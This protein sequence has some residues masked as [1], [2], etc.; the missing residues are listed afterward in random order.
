MSKI[1]PKLNLNK[2]PQL[3]E[4]NSLIMAKN[5]RLLKDNTIGPDT[6]LEEIEVGAVIDHEE[7]ITVVDEEPSVVY[8]DQYSISI[9]K[10]EYYCRRKPDRDYL[11]T[12]G[13]YYYNYVFDPYN[14]TI[15]VQGTVYAIPNDFLIEGGSSFRIYPEE[16]VASSTYP[17]C[18]LLYLI[19]FRAYNGSTTFE[20]LINNEVA[21][22]YYAIGN[23][24]HVG[25]TVFVNNERYVVVQPW[26]ITKDS[27]PTYTG[28][29]SHTETINVYDP[30]RYI[31]Q[32]VGLNNKIYFFKEATE[33]QFTEAG[34]TYPTNENDKVRIFEYDEISK[35]FTIVKCGWRYSGGVIDGEV[36]T[37]NTTELILTICECFETDTNILVPIKHINLSKCK[38][39]DD[40]SIYTQTPNIPFTNLYFVDYYQCTIPNG[41][42]QFFIRYKIRNDFY[43]EW[44]PCSEE[45]YAGYPVTTE[46]IQGTLRYVDH[47]RDC[48]RSFKFNVEHL[49]DG[50]NN[51][52]D[53]TKNFSEFQIGFI[54][55]HDD[56]VVARSW[57]SFPFDNENRVSEIY[58]DYDKNVIKEIDIDEIL[59]TNYE[60][61]NVKNLAYYKNKLFIANYEETNFNPDLQQYANNIE[62]TLS[63]KIITFNDDDASILGKSLTKSD[64]SL[65]YFDKWGGVTAN[66]LITVSDIL[67]DATISDT[68]VDKDY[69]NTSSTKFVLKAQMYW[70]NSKDIDA[71]KNYY[72]NDVYW[73]RKLELGLSFYNNSNQ[74][75]KFD[76]YDYTASDNP[77]DAGLLGPGSA[78]RFWV[79]GVMHTGGNDL[80]GLRWRWYWRGGSI[81]AN[82]APG[83]GWR[84]FKVYPFGLRGQHEAEAQWKNTFISIIKRRYPSLV[85]AN[86]A[87][88]YTGGSKTIIGENTYFVNNNTEIHGKPVAYNQKYTDT[89]LKSYVFGLLKNH[90]VGV[91]SGAGTNNGK[92]VISDN[93]TIR[94][95]TSITAVFITLD[96]SV[97]CDNAE[98]NNEITNDLYVNAVCK[99]RT[100]SY[101]CDIKNVELNNVNNKYEYKTLMPFTDYEFYIHYVKQN[102]VNTNG[103]YIGTKRFNDYTNIQTTL[104]IIY[105]TFSN[106]VIPDG[107]VGYFIT[108]NKIKNDVARLFNVRKN[109]TDKDVAYMYA[110]CLEC[111]TMLYPLSKN[112]KIY[113]KTSNQNGFVLTP[114]STNGE[115]FSSGSNNPLIE[116]G[117]CGEVRW[118]LDPNRQEE[119]VRYESISSTLY[120]PKNRQT[121]GVIVRVGIDDTNKTAITALLKLNDYS[122]NSGIDIQ[123]FS[124]ALAN[125]VSSYDCLEATVTPKYNDIWND[126]LTPAHGQGRG[127]SDAIPM[128]ELKGYDITVYS[129]D[130]TTN[131]VTTNNILYI[132][133][134]LVSADIMGE[135]DRAIYR[136]ENY[137]VTEEDEPVNVVYN[138]ITLNTFLNDIINGVQIDDSITPDIAKIFMS[139]IK[140]SRILENTYWIVI[141]NNDENNKNKRLTKI[142]PFIR[143]SGS[144]DNY[145]LNLPG[146]INVIGKLEHDIADKLY[147]SGSD[148]YNK[149]TTVNNIKLEE[150]EGVVGNTASRRFYIPSNFNLNCVTLNE[151]ITP[152]IRS[153]LPDLN[154]TDDMEKQ[155]MK[156][157]NSL[158]CS[159]ILTLP[160]MYYDFIRKYYSVYNT[161]QRYKFDN[162]IRSSD[163][164]IDET[165]RNIY[166]FRSEDYYNIPVNRG[167]ITNLFNLANYIYVHTEHSLFKF[168]GA[169]SL[170]SVEGDVTL[171]ET[172]VFD[173]GI[174]EL[175]DAKNGYAGLKHKKQSIVMFDSYVFWDDYVQQIYAFGGEGK[176]ISISDSIDKVIKAFKPTDIQFVANETN[177][178]FFINLRNNEDNICFSYNF[179]V[180]AIV[181][182][183][184]LDFS[185]GFNTRLHTYFV[186]T[187]I[188]ENQEI[189]WS[190]YHIIDNLVVDNNN[191]FIAYQN[192]WK[193]SVIK[194]NDIRH[195]EEQEAVFGIAEASVDIICNIEY[196]LVKELDYINWI[197]SEISQYGFTDNCVAEETLNRKYA[198]NKLRIYTDE[199]STDLISLVDAQ[200]N[201]LI[202]NEA[203]LSSP[204]SYKYPRYNC[205]VWSINY[206][207]DIQNRD[208]LFHYT[209]SRNQITGGVGHS[210]TTDLTPYPQRRLY[211]QESN[212]IYGK[213]IV[214]RLI[215][216]NRNFKLENVTF[217]L[218]NY[219]KVK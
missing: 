169:N 146:F 153:Y 137:Y 138:A 205:G 53:Y 50:Q 106:I 92:F 140:Y 40:E 90:I 173:S 129:V 128:D 141:D 38:E 151:D 147:V 23:A 34:L 123:G 81:N 2:T 125:V 102:G 9:W 165:Y 94:E 57:K 188:Y 161:E 21:P 99:Q 72:E 55:S 159:S 122:T 199:C 216:D 214:L 93:G 1:V 54:L 13:V 116:F 166:K 42:Y 52:I 120:L 200:G 134:T 51:T 178:R 208:D 32:I 189:G 87:I 114:I 10:P 98:N 154:N 119:T 193:P 64:N 130:H 97:D 206:F 15:V 152:I 59:K 181:S 111:D 88:N 44:F 61:F 105:P 96:Y 175:F 217:R 213:Y 117:N 73:L 110:D 186:H 168:G 83:N 8:T 174:F 6:S 132:G 176:I 158:T 63:D 37:N 210:K 133:L 7:T 190:I 171:K 41:V 201:A 74:Y 31:G 47:H 71:S 4:N 22:Y 80:G 144:Y 172:D 155:V 209:A 182:V 121:G 107:Y 126:T 164:N 48:P 26:T 95:I 204:E 14:S 118:P 150:V 36:T 149:V 58:F 77:G 84:I 192:C 35:T 113:R 5:I 27:V 18:G 43:T 139:S 101:S 39:D 211:T 17:G 66:N 197:C 78:H 30:V 79:D 219:G 157:V 46:T 145:E 198:G 70:K 177:D 56:T 195:E 75:A 212:L 194:I 25:S 108:I 179:K 156:A 127:G 184:D 89:Q 19:H 85:L 183:H 109:D 16:V 12:N 131:N 76:E 82:Q 20:T 142:T 100:L 29:S 163:A 167:I 180:N 196:E 112:I 62:V 86:L 187:D 45:L 218:N 49:F 170:S 60:L 33:E 11:T 28:G 143:T 207:R 203:S 104:Q 148:V 215:F 124:Q 3:V 115:Y 162:T 67:E 202:S 160:T 136:L 135:I 24:S 69:Y 91:R 191:Y 65:T 185:F 68:T 103:Y